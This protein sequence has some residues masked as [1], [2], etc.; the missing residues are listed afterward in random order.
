MTTE[1]RNPTAASA[2]SDKQRE[3][4]R[5]Q[6]EKDRGKPSES[7]ESEKSAVQAGAREHPEKLP[8]QHI[9]KPGLESELQLKP[10]FLAPDYEGSRKLRDMVAL[11]TGGDSGIGRAVTRVGAQPDKVEAYLRGTH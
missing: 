10:Q 3:I 9:E 11:V 4:Q 8:A 7:G 2:V 6:D 5:S 1:T